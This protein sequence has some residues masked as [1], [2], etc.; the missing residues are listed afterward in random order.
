MMTGIG[1]HSVY[2]VPALWGR[3][4]GDLG[5]LAALAVAA[6]RPDGGRDRNAW[7]AMTAVLG[8]TVIDA[9][10]A[11]KLAEETKEGKTAGPP[12]DYSTR[13]GF[14][15]GVEAAR[16]AGIV[17][18]AMAGKAGGAAAGDISPAGA[19]TSGQSSTD[20]VGAPAA[21]GQSGSGGSQASSGSSQSQSSSQQT[22]PSGLPGGGQTMPEEAA[23]VVPEPPAYTPA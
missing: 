14:P 3:F 8:I 5:D 15:G 10:V 12:K 23:K 16:G 19:T 22:A 13:S 21:G 11:G 2:P 4:A 20:L 7:I 9:L 6:R 18:D 17:R 1:A